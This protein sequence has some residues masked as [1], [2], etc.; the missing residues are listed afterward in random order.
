MNYLIMWALRE[1]VIA[2]PWWTFCAKS[3][4]SISSLY[5][6]ADIVFWFFRAAFVTGRVAVIQICIT[7]MIGTL[8]LR[9]LALT[10]GN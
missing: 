3:K 10:I 8:T 5:K 6:W 2:H 7:A 4:G 9:D 1:Q